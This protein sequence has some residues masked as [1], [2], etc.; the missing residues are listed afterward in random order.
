[1]LETMYHAEGVGL[2]APQV[3][4]LRRAVVVDIGEGPILMINPEIVEEE[5]EISGEE[6]CLSVPMKK[7]RVTRPE[8]IKVKY[9][10]LENEDVEL[11][12]SE[13]LARA[14]YHEVDHLN[15]IL[16]TDRATKMYRI[17]EEEENDE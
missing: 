12:A 10:N 7:G 6:A 14:I 8:K 4:V 3:G 1:M 11:E 5:G 16:Y 2:A 17:V 9:K 13:F 15:G